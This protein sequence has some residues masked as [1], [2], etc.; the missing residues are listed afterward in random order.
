M[1]NKIEQNPMS[2]ASKTTNQRILDILGSA[3]I[4]FLAVNPL[5]PNSGSFYPTFQIYSPTDSISQTSLVPM[6]VLDSH[7]YKI[8][9]LDSRLVTLS[10]GLHLTVP[11]TT[12]S[13]LL[14]NPSWD[15]PILKI[16]VPTRHKR[17]QN[18]MGHSFKLKI[19]IDEILSVRDAIL[20]YKERHSVEPI[21]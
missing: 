17:H 11:L 14:Y 19:P 4:A 15:D 2:K 12:N 21:S 8:E 6:K 18:Y 3:E 5:E 9:P 7:E 10:G 1:R 20:D 16:K 13:T